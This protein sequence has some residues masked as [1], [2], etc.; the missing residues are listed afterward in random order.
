MGLSCNKLISDEL[1]AGKNNYLPKNAG[2]LF[3]P[4][5]LNELNSTIYEKSQKA[6]QA[7]WKN[8]SRPLKRRNSAKIGPN[9]D[10]SEEWKG[11]LQA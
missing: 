11:V 8:S 7:A 5:F 9:A 2:F 6:F 10:I 1:S 3:R 4:S